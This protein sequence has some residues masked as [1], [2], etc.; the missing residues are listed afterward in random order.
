MSASE[1]LKAHMDA[2]RSV[3]TT[4]DK[5]SISDATK[6]LKEPQLAEAFS[7]DPATFWENQAEKK[8]MEDS[9][10]RFTSTVSNA[11]NVGFYILSDAIKNTGATTGN[12]M[13]ECMIRGTVSLNRIGEESQNQITVDLLFNESRWK[14]L[15]FPF[16]W[17]GGT[18]D[19]YGNHLPMGE[20]FEISQLRFI[21]MN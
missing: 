9:V 2:V 11:Y 14:V 21:K 3:T 4:S 1:I 19:F 18:F 17:S 13:F 15:R 16:A 6:V 5:L 8:K 12:Y 7:I 20:W 10:W